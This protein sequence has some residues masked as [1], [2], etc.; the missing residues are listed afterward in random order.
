MPQPAS[1]STGTLEMWN[2][3]DVVQGFFAFFKQRCARVNIQYDSRIT[4][5]GPD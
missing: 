3:M 4:F 2:R 5:L 1:L